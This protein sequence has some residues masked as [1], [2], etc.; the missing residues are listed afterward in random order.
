[1][2][3]IFPLRQNPWKYLEHD[4]STP[5]LN[6]ARPPWDGE[7]QQQWVNDPDDGLTPVVAG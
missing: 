3:G 7:P 6:A 4:A 2:P 1:M 5:T